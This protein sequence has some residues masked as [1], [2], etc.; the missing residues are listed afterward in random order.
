MNKLIL[1]L[2]FASLAFSF[3]F[4]DMSDFGG[5]KGG[6]PSMPSMG[7]FGNMGG[8]GDSKDAHHGGMSDMMSNINSQFG[9]AGDSIKCIMT[10]CSAQIQ[11]C[12]SDDDCKST[13]NCVQECEK[14]YEDGDAQ[15]YCKS[16]C[17]SDMLDNKPFQNLANCQGECFVKGGVF[18]FTCFGNECKSQWS[19]CQNDKDCQKAIDC[20]NTCFGD[21][22]CMKECG[23]KIPGRLASNLFQC[24]AECFANHM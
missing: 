1:V 9:H 20:G 23:N 18:P 4:G 16:D 19:A 6:M 7:S 24:S 3:S 10:E 13:N 8:N 11:A 22:D 5:K 17:A 21:E 2:A 14:N 15:N 12:E